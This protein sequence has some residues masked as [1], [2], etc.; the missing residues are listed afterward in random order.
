MAHHYSTEEMN[1]NITSEFQLNPV[2]MDYRQNREPVSKANSAYRESHVSGDTC[3]IKVVTIGRIYGTRGHRN[4]ILSKSAVRLAIDTEVIPSVTFEKSP[5][6]GNLTNFK[7]QIFSGILNK[8]AVEILDSFEK[9]F[10]SRTTSTFSELSRKYKSEKS[11]L[12]NQ[13][14]LSD[15]RGRVMFTTPKEQSE[16]FNSLKDL[17]F[18][19][20]EIYLS[21]KPEN[22]R[23][24]RSKSLRCAT[25]EEAEALNN[26]LRSLCE[27]YQE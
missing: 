6:R 1:T 15:V 4:S 14:G 22:L 12:V 16:Y 13:L 9:R 25:L 24:T 21:V 17:S 8:N 19:Y 23:V 20:Y 7:P 5:V 10:G 26:K 18:N 2:S 3:T 27:S 11:R